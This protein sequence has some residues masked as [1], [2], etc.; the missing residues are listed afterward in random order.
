MILLRDKRRQIYAQGDI[1]G[2]CFLYS[3]INA[4]TALTGKHS[5]FENICTMLAHVK[6]PQDFLVGN[7]GTQ[8]GYAQESSLISTTIA[9]CLR[10]LGEENFS[11]TKLAYQEITDISNAID[12]NSVVLVHYKGDT[13]YMEN[14]N[15]WVCCV[16]TSEA[17]ELANEQMTTQAGNQARTQDGTIIHVAC[18]VMLQKIF[19]YYENYQEVYHHDMCR[20]S[21]DEL[22]SKTKIVAE[23]VYIV[24]LR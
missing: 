18:S 19:L 24:T 14:M 20:W 7:V 4:F 8:R 1:D 11:V 23:D 21:N 3:I 5:D 9:Q 2:A 10:F 12:K 13:K 22:T 6:F 17:N 16:A 15:H